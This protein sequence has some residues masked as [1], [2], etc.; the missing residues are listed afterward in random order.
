MVALACVAFL[1]NQTAQNVYLAE[2][3]ARAQATLALTVQALDGH[4]RRFEQVPTLLAESGGVRQ[5]LQNP[6]N[7]V[8][9][10]FLNR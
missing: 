1:G 9:R 2:G 10:R 6:Q 4:L 5:T 8:S 3:A 7:L